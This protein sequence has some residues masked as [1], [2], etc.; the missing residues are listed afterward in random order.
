VLG[1]PADHRLDRASHIS[2]APLDGFDLDSEP[3]FLEFH[4]STSEFEDWQNTCLVFLLFNECLKPEET[5]S[6]MRLIS[7]ESGVLFRAEDG[8]A[9]GHGLPW[10]GLALVD[11][12]VEQGFVQPLDVRFLAG[13]PGYCLGE[14]VGQVDWQT[15]CFLDAPD[16]CVEVDE[17]AEHVVSDDAVS[18]FGGRRDE[19]NHPAASLYYHLAIS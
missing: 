8:R 3:E 12:G 7:E 19:L 9:G 6:P 5:S 18:L 10:D 14:G 17:Q 1:I 4:L 13:D 11:T 15:N 2:T 16:P